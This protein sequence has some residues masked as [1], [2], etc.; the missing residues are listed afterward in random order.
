MALPS[1]DYYSAPDYAAVRTAYLAYIAKSLELAGSSAD[2]AKTQAKDVLA[3]ETRLASAS[4]APVDQRNPK[5]MYHFVSVAEADKATPHFS[6]T[7]FLATQDV[8]VGK[9]FVVPA[10]VFRSI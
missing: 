10:A 4:L 2:E 7:R 9:G 6:W 5:N 1:K 3:L 8:E